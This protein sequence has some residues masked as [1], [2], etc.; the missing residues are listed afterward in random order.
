STPAPAGDAGVLHEQRPPHAEEARA[1]LDARLRRVGAGNAR[2]RAPKS[3]GPVPVCGSAAWTRATPAS[4]APKGRGELREQPPPARTSG[5]QGA[6]P[7][8]DGT[9]REGAA[10]AR[11]PPAAAPPTRTSLRSRP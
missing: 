3:H 1:C 8:E 9:G 10:G 2:S 6:A 5:V 7:L 4:S 11:K